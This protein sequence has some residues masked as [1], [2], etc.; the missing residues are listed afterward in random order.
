MSGAPGCFRLTRRRG[1]SGKSLP[2]RPLRGGR[3][4]CGCRARTESSKAPR[5]ADRSPHWGSRC[6]YPTWIAGR[7]WF[8]GHPEAIYHPQIGLFGLD[9]HP[10]WLRALEAA[11]Q[12]NTGTSYVNPLPYLWLT[13]P[14]SRA[15]SLGAFAAL[16]LFANALSALVLGSEAM[17]LAGHPGLRLRLLAPGLSKSYA[18]VV[19]RLAEIEL[20]TYNNASLRSALHRSKSSCSRS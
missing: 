18:A 17:R 5:G 15:V 20:V 16:Y 14:V 13:A 10:E 1:P 11:G 9:A 3:L 7:L 12:I 4:R 8:A 6:C 19:A 2:E